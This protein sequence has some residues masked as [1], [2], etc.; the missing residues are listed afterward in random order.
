[1]PND[2]NYGGT[3]QAPLELINAQQAWDIT[4]G[5]P[6]VLI[7]ITDTYFETTHEDLVNQIIQ[8]FD[9]YTNPS[10]LDYHGVLV[11]GLVAAETNNNKGIS[12][13][14][15]NCKLVT[16]DKYGDHNEVLLISQIPNVKVINLS[17]RFCNYSLT[18]DS[19][20]KAIWDSGVIVV[21]GAA[22]GV[23][24]TSCGGGHGYAYPA[25]YPYTISVSSVGHIVMV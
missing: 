23:G 8:N 2:Y 25:S 9:H 19:L 10:N 7:G 24:G 11:S 20:Y 12:G 6:N 4:T 21:C 3:P 1:M 13:I 15:Y 17:W 14:G 16:S 22:N 5:D 18:L